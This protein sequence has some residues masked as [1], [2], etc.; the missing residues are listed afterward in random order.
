MANMISKKGEIMSD[1][2]FFLFG[3]FLII[4]S[5]MLSILITNT[6]KHNHLDNNPFPK[7]FSIDNVKVLEY[8]PDKDNPGFI[9][10]VLKIDATL[11]TPDKMSK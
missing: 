2:R 10:C 6:K 4:V 1:T 8:H 5:I 9:K 3:L 11:K 7:V